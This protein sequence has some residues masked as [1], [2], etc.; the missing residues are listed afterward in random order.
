MGWGRSMAGARGCE[1]RFRVR[2][3]AGKG[4]AGRQ[5][6][7]V[8]W[9]GRGDG[10]G[11]GASQVLL[12]GAL[13]WLASW[14]CSSGVRHAPGGV[15]RPDVVVEEPPAVRPMDGSVGRIVRVH[16]GLRFVVVDFGLSE[17][18][19]AGARLGVY[20]EGAKVGALKAGHFRRDATMAADVILGEVA[21][22]D[23][24]RP[25]IAD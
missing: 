19:K 9:A 6:R 20:R 17:V 22:G 18:P 21:E 16:A 14:G 4:A 5:H 1:L 3:L 15:P 25:E 13:A 2:G 11:L 23:E 24:V 8:V 10:G 7:R 12:L